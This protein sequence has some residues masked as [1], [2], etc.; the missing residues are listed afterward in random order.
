MLLESVLYG[1]AAGGY[2]EIA[3]EFDTLS[4]ILY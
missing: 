2:S 1:R 4:E 3:R